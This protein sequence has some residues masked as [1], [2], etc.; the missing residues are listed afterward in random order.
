[1]FSGRFI[2]V[3]HQRRR[4]VAGMKAVSSGTLLS[5][6]NPSDPDSYPHVALSVFQI[7]IALPVAVG[8]YH[9]ALGLPQMFFG[10]DWKP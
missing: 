7:R 5:G 3:K 6:P 1:M 10:L 4:G 2:R 8:A 9:R